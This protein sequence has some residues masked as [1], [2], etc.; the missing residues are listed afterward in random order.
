MPTIMSQSPHP[1]FRHPLT[2]PL[3]LRSRLSRSRR[4]GLTGR[5]GRIGLTGWKLLPVLLVF[6]VVWGAS[7]QAGCKKISMDS[8]QAGT[9]EA[10]RIVACASPAAGAWSVLPPQKATL[11]PT[12]A[13]AW[14][15]C[16]ASLPRTPFGTARNVPTDGDYAFTR[17]LIRTLSPLCR[18]ACG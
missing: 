5:I 2:L 3:P 10:V 14:E 4:I 13:T 15:A 17:T 6:A 18:I 11:S 7:P 16:A 1:L 8:L 12:G 9:S